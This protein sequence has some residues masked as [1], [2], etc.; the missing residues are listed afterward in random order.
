MELSREGLKPAPSYSTLGLVIIP[1]WTILY[2]A[3]D[4]GGLFVFFLLYLLLICTDANAECIIVCIVVFVPWCLMRTVMYLQRNR[5]TGAGPPGGGMAAPLMF[6]GGG[7]VVGRGNVV[8]GGGG[9]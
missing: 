5:L 2:L 1:L 8:L 7:L 4:A 9:V 6:A 3:G